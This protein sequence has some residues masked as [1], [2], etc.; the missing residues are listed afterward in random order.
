MF[1]LARLHA[2]TRSETWADGGKIQASGAGTASLSL[3]DFFP[4]N[5]T[6][7]RAA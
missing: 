7:S 3:T 6:L 4:G 1:H 5:G 2:F